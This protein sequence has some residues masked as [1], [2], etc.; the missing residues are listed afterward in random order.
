MF[1][2]KQTV[3]LIEHKNE[4]E[5]SAKKFCLIPKSQKKLMLFHILCTEYFFVLVIYLYK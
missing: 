2:L 1:M 3:F 4:Q 5:N